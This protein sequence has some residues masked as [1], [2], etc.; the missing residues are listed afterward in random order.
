MRFSRQPNGKWCGYSTVSDSF[1]ESH[2]TEEQLLVEVIRDMAYQIVQ[3]Y[4]DLLKDG[5]YDF[6][7]IIDAFMYDNDDKKTRAFWERK[8]KMMGCSKEQM[9]KVKS[10]IDY[11]AENGELK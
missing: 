1:Y 8:F 4:M 3:R 7:N 9:E 2:L 6:E 5:G 10:R 11:L